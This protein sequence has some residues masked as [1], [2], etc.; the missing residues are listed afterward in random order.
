MCLLF[1]ACFGAYYRPHL[2]AQITTSPWLFGSVSVSSIVCAYCCTL[3]LF[4]LS[5]K[6]TTITKTNAKHTQE[7]YAPTKYLSRSHIPR[8]DNNNDVDN[9]VY[10]RHTMLFDALHIKATHHFKHLVFSA[11]HLLALA[12]YYY[13]YCFVRFS[14]SCF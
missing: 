1:S 12:Y 8:D 4:L 11:F 10:W 7:Y 13:Y 9:C 6:Y 3:R 14:E 5:T 2:R